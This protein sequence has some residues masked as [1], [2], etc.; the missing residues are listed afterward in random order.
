M[1]PPML[2]EA[3]WA[4]NMDLAR[5]LVE[6][7][8][9]STVLERDQS[10]SLHAVVRRG[11]VGLTHLLIEYG[12]DGVTPLHLAVRK[13]R[14]DLP[15][16]LV[17]YGADTMAKD[18]DGSIPLHLVAARES[19]GAYLARFLVEQGVDATAYWQDNRGRTP[20]YFASGAGRKD[21][22]SF[23]VEHGAEHNHG[24]LSRTL[25]SLVGM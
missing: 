25:Y 1:G 22:A 2:R 19:G 12:K 10:T 20:L 24:R 15:R 3:V 21:L 17:D 11:S 5:L 4:Q 14:V 6:Y 18:K 13:A 7:G 9:D 16:L 8:A 23:L